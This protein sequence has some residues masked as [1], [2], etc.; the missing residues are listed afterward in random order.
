[1]Y[2]VSSL[3][4]SSRLL[5]FVTTRWLFTHP[6][7]QSGHN[8]WSKIKDKKAAHDKQKS[9]LYARMNNEIIIAAKR[10]GSADP[11]KNILL[12]NA[13]K[14]AKEQGVPKENIAKSLA[15]VN[16]V[17]GV[18]RQANDLPTKPLLLIP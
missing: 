1:M 12:S 2:Q 3:H 15:R 4:F 18:K 9:V 7:I 5:P 8:K 13:L 14:K 6:P 11:D 10:G 16:H 17:L